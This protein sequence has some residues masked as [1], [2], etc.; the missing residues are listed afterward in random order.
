MCP[1][2]EEGKVDEEKIKYLSEQ[3]ATNLME[4]IFQLS[5]LFHF[6]INYIFTIALIYPT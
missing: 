1:E 3:Y 5:F 2:L 6:F 4:W